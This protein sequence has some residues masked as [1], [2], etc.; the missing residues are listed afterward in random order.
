MTLTLYST[1][2]FLGLFIGPVIAGNTANIHGWRSFF[3][4]STGLAA[5]CLIILVCLSPETKFHRDFSRAPE[6]TIEK[7]EDG[8]VDAD[9][10]ERLNVDLPTLELN[11]TTSTALV[12]EGKPARSQFNF[13][14]HPDHRWRELLFR[15]IF[16]PVRAFLYP[17]IFWAA[18]SVA[19]PA[20]LLLFWNLTESAVLSGPPY[21]WNPSQVGYSNFSFAVGGIIGLFTAGPFS[22]WVAQRATKR[23]DGIREAEMRLPALIPYAILTGI[24]TVIGGIAY[25][26]SWDWEIICVIGYGFTGLSVTTIPTIAIAYAIDCYKP[27]SGEIMV[28]ATVVKN[29]CGFGMSYW[30]APL[31]VQ[32]GYI[33]PAMVEFALTIGPMFLAIPLYFWGKKL[34]QL[35]AKSNL[36][37]LEEM[38]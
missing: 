2:Y 29:T 14:Q 8:Y 11:Q 5:F 12:G 37:R 28:V 1:A 3:W 17:I 21:N 19:G 7:N 35:T 38:L 20:N 6:S 27:I 15:D 10:N 13:I 24:G 16:S 33:S 31:A 30:V 25:Q 23:N 9:K 36:H 26:R 18:L 34:R 32:E 22:D 4:L